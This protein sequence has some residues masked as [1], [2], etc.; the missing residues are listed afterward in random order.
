MTFTITTFSITTLSITIL[1]IMTLSITVLS[2]IMLSVV[3]FHCCDECLLA[4][5]WMLWRNNT[6]FSQWLFHLK[7]LEDTMVDDCRH[8]PSDTA[9]V[10][11]TRGCFVELQK[12]LTKNRDAVGI[13]TLTIVAFLVLTLYNFNPFFS[14]FYTY[15]CNEALSPTRWQYQSQV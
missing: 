12:T 5:C 1:S 11:R 6:C 14:G 8:R 4:E 7:Q 2:A 15:C 10:D 9:Y 13:A 3:I